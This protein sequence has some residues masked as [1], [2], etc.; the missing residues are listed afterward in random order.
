M[1]LRC[2]YRMVPQP[3]TMYADYHTCYIYVSLLYYVADV[4]WHPYT[5]DVTDGFCIS[6]EYLRTYW[7]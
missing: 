6:C 7:E 5:Y 2:R 4:N 1:Y 3:I